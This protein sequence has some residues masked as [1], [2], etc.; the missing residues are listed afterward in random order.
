MHY[1]KIPKLGAYLAVP[2]IYNSYLSEKI[3]DIALEAKNKYLEDLKEFNEK[4]EEELAEI[5]PSKEELEKK[6]SELKDKN[7]DDPNIEG[8]NA[9]LEEVKTKIAEKQAETIQ[10]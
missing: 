3:F 2:L 10:E 9:E 1:F 4:K 6:I 7:A 5:I 8:L